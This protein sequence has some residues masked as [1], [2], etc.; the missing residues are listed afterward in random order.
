MVVAAPATNKTML[1]KIQALIESGKIVTVAKFYEGSADIINYVD[2]NTG[3][4]ATMRQIKLVVGLDTGK[5]KKV[6]SATLRVA[7]GE[8]PAQVLASM[9]LQE[10]SRVLLEIDSLSK[11]APSTKGADSTWVL[12]LHGAHP[13]ETPATEPATT[14]EP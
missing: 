11:I 12:R 1:E 6:V 13:Y 4:P 14:T 8:D 7:E 10:G 3:K 2:K 9:G 5:G